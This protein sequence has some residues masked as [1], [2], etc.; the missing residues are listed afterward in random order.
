MCD[1]YS[2]LSDKALAKE[3]ILEAKR[4]GFS[5]EDIAKAI[6][7]SP[8]EIRK[9]RVKE[10]LRPIF[11]QVKTGS[12]PYFYSSYHNEAR[13]FNGNIEKEKSLIVLGSG[14][15]RIGQGIEFDYST[16][17]AA[18]ALKES[19]YKAIIINNNPETVSTDYFTSDRL[20]FEPLSEEEVWEI[21]QLERPEGILVQF[22]GQTA[23]NLVDFIENEGC[24]SWGLVL[25]IS[26]AWKTANNLTQ[27]WSY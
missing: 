17:H 24:Q 7:I 22:G 18:W 4:L 20:Y 2:S 10:G 21:Y 11:N 19:G 9:F 27:V 16:V 6:K 14:P 26:L 15:I 3:T 8:L 1:F 25:L 13:Q 23:I 5:D 12:M